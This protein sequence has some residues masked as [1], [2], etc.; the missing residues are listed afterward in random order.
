MTPLIRFMSWMVAIGNGGAAANAWHAIEE[1]AQADAA[2]DALCARV[3]VTQSG[4]A[5]SSSTQSGNTQ[6]GSTAPSRAA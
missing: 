2:V 5:Q 6:S 1:R 4:N 3:N